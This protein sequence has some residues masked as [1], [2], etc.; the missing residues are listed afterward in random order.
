MIP[1]AQHQNPLIHHD[2]VLP[3]LSLIYTLICSTPSH[4][5]PLPPFPPGALA[6]DFSLF[7]WLIS[8]PY[9]ELGNILPPKMSER[10]HKS[11]SGLSICSIILPLT[12]RNGSFTTIKRWPFSNISISSP[13]QKIPFNPR[14]TDLHLEFRPAFTP[15]RPGLRRS[16]LMILHQD[17]FFGPFLKLSFSSLE[18]PPPQV[19]KAPILDF[20]LKLSPALFSTFCSLSQHSLPSSTNL[21]FRSLKVFNFLGRLIKLPAFLLPSSTPVFIHSPPQSAHP[22]NQD[23]HLGPQARLD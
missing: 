6:Q 19:V 7:S 8:H 23:P 17:F 4:P 15:L 5:P 18:F 9:L 11:Y 10:I 13:T 1:Y 14:P 3:A 21:P 12:F 20:P 22:L 2:N 16:P